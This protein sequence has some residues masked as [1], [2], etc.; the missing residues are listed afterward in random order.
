[1][2][3]DNIQVLKGNEFVHSHPEMYWGKKNPIT[4]D[5]VKALVEQIEILKCGPA[6]VHHEFEWCFVGSEKD[7]LESALVD[8][9]EIRDIFDKGAGFPEAGGLSM[10][11]EFFLAE[12]SEKVLL[13][14]SGQIIA[15]KGGRQEDLDKVTEFFKKNYKGSIAVCF[16]GN[17]Y[18]TQN[19]CRTDL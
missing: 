15:I 17:T 3:N 1:M 16:T 14:H 18:T 12:F 11:C 19:S 2:D 5:V 9:R 10:R 13:W 4:E 6:I 7:W 8:G